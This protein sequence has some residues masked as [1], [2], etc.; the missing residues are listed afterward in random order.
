MFEFYQ[1]QNLV[2]QYLKLIYHRGENPRH[3]AEIKGGREGGRDCRAQG[4]HL[5]DNT[6]AELHMPCSHTLRDGDCAHTHLK[7][8]WCIFRTAR[9]AQKA[10]IK[11][12]TLR[13]RE[14]QWV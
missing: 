2:S 1:S 10:A 3:G 13:A 5:G 9:T 8:S 14:I 12:G 11:P 6:R 7:S 4:E